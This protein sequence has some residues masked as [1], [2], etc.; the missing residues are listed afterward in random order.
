MSSKQPTRKKKSAAS[1]PVIDPPGYQPTLGRKIL[2][3]CLC[4]VGLIIV[5]T[6]Y[7]YAK[8]APAPPVKRPAATS[9]STH[10]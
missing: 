8:N 9:V 7:F 10:P 2:M 4:I 3:F 5:W 1:T 6:S